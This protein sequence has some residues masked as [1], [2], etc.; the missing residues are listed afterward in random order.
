M[1]VRVIKYLINT[2]NPTQ[3]GTDYVFFR[4]ADALLMKAEA[5]FHK[6]ETGP[7]LDII[8]EIRAHRGAAELNNIS[9]EDILNERGYELYWEG[10]RRN[11]L[12][13]FGAC[14]LMSGIRNQRPMNSGYSFPIPQ[15]A[16][17]TNPN[18][19]QTAG[20]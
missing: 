13:R 11:D 4:Y 17:D 9:E 19:V 8:N 1:G 7:A 10:W 20:Y 3:P 5:H 18:L 14:S 15:R 6:G 2:D 12:V 16:L